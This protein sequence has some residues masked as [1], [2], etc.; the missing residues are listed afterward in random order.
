MAARPASLLKAP[1]LDK[2]H[3]H[4]VVIATLPGPEHTLSW[5]TPPVIGSPMYKNCRQARAWSWRVRLVAEAVRAGD[6]E[7]TKLLL[8][9]GADPDAGFPL[10]IAAREDFRQIAKMLIE[11]GANVHLEQD[12]K[13]P[14]EIAI[15][16][17]NG[18][19]MRCIFA[20]GEN[21]R[22]PP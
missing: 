15:D 13:N 19:I 18:T 7:V 21:V 16:W 10:H 5:N 9:D 2:F 3:D 14:L 11:D 8:D 1:P 4:F 6:G 12:G 22:H 20:T 17:K